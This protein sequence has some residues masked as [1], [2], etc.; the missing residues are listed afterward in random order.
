MPFQNQRAKIS[1]DPEIRASL[2]R[3]SRSRSESAQ[4]IEWARILP[5]NAQGSTGSTIA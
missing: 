3:I 2:E 1:F 4:R 5:M